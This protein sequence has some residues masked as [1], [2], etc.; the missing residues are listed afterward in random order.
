[1]ASSL[2]AWACA[3]M[4]A[5]ARAVE[6]MGVVLVVVSVLGTEMAGVEVRPVA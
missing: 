5:V 2:S 3:A 6:A 1:M 4:A